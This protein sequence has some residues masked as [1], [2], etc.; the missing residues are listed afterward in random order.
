ML[1]DL[2]PGEKFPTTGSA[3]WIGYEDGGFEGAPQQA[4][5]VSTRP[6]QQQ[7]RSFVTTFHALKMAAPEQSPGTP[8]TPPAGQFG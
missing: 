4:L 8:V 2:P 1:I 7:G 6:V 3:G 5:Q